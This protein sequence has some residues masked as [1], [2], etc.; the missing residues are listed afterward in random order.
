MFGA[1]QVTQRCTVASEVTLRGKM[2]LAQHKFG[3]AQIATKGAAT[4]VLNA[5]GLNELALVVDVALLPLYHGQMRDGFHPRMVSTFF[6]GRHLELKVLV[7]GD[8]FTP[9]TLPNPHFLA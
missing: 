1:R 4:A 5:D 9:A 8:A 7:K 6:Y 3:Q 2:G